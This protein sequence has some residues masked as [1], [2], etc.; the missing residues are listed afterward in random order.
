MSLFGFHRKLINAFHEGERREYKRLIFLSFLSIFLELIGQA[1]LFAILMVVVDYRAVWEVLFLADLNQLANLTRLELIGVFTGAYL[2]KNVL[3]LIL[4]RHQYKKLFGITSAVSS[5]L[6]ADT[7]S[8]D[9]EGFKKIVSGEKLNEIISVTNSLPT[10]V[11]LPAVTVITEVG[12]LL[13]VLIILALVNPILILALLGVLVPPAILFMLFA[14]RRLDH[15]GRGITNTMPTLYSSVQQAIF[16]FSEIKLFQLEKS[17][18]RRFDTARQEVYQNRI[19]AHILSGVVPQRLMEVLAVFGVFILAWYFQVLDSKANVAATLALF[20]AAAFRLLPSLNRLVSSLNTFNTFSNILE[21]IP[22][23]QE[24]KEDTDKATLDILDFESLKIRNL[25]FQFDDDSNL[26]DGVSLDINRGDM[27]GIYGASGIGKTTL[28][29]VLLGF[30]RVNDAVITV[31]GLK[32]NDQLSSWH[33]ISGYVKQDSFLLPSSI[34][35]NIAFGQET[36]DENRLT[37]VLQ[38]AQLSEWIES[39]P[40]GLETRIGENG[41]R[42][43]GGQRQ[44]IAI[45]RCLYKQ[46]SIWFLDEATNSLD[47]ETKKEL[48]DNLQEINQSGTTMVFVT[49]DRE[50]L[51][52]CKTRYRL[53][54][55]KLKES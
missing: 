10:F 46:A 39:I 27:I 55:G 25:N 54:A 7:F 22:K 8:T 23:P 5:D 28:I 32:M 17:Y 11:I 34:K 29:N 48:L 53:V 52:R 30:Y 36:I 35:E 14:K 38:K 2:I 43:S 1:F 21:F 45:A 3:Q 42:I 18:I 37:E 40:E 16:G 4:N 15:Y 9:L 13:L 6:Y 31:N 12:F 33:Q 20:A 51:E 49:H 50:V 41:S 44:R 26:I 47:D 24:G 19:E